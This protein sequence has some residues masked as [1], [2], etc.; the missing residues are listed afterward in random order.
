[1]NLFEQL[2]S[3]MSQHIIEHQSE[4]HTLKDATRKLLIDDIG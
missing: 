3:S 2:P 1:M 4:H